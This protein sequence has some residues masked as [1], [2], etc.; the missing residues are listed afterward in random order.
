MNTTSPLLQPRSPLLILLLFLAA[1]AAA[2]MAAEPE[3]STPAAQDAA[4]HIVYVDRPEGADAEEFHIRTL[5]PVLGSE[6][7][8]KDAVLYHYKHAASG[9]SAKLTPAQVEDLKSESPFICSVVHLRLSCG[10]S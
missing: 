2:A 5:A 4:V 10:A 6:E 8:A 1:T 9:F 3:Q 7:K